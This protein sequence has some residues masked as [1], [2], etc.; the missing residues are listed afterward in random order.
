MHVHFV[1]TGNICR[2]PMAEALLRARSDERGFS[3]R[4]SS[5][6]TWAVDGEPATEG[7]I[8]AMESRGIDLSFH[9]SKPFEPNRG[10]EA[11]LIIA[12]TSVHLREIDAA[13]PGSPVKTR[14]LKELHELDV[15]EDGTPAARLH[16]LLESPRPPWMRSLDLDDPMGLPF[17]A[18]EVCAA[19]I[20][21]GIERL[22]D[23]LG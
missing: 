8:A 23:L 1:C 15:D 19:E 22:L 9:R 13:L 3:L 2:S 14:L 18:Y 17:G 16:S 4:I 6:G 7:A 12:M 5:S 21:R 10:R 11:D 20:D